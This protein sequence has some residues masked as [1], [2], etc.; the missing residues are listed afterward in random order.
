MDKRHIQ[1]DAHEQL[2]R[3]EAAY[4]TIAEQPGQPLGDIIRLLR[5]ELLITLDEMSKL[6]GVSVRVIHGIE[7]KEGNPTLATAE[8]LLRPFGMQLGVVSKPKNI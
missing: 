1:P 3:R 5:K 2:A 6:T 7:N 4:Q 8:K